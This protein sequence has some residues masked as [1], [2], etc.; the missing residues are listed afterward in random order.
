MDEKRKSTRTGLQAALLLKRIDQQTGEKV[1]IQ[2]KDVSQNGIGF[3]CDRELDLG[4]I[5]ECNLTLWTKEVI[6]CFLEIIRE[7]K[8][9]DEYTYGTTFVG[10]TEMEAQRIQVYQTV[11]EY[12]R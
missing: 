10:M 1:A 5:Y 8:S 3:W 11:E 4:A 7:E 6:Q 9:K 2:I 12:S